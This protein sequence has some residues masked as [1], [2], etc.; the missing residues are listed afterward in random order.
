MTVPRPEYP[1]PQ[2]VRDGY[3]NLNGEWEF[4]FDFGRSG[5]DRKM[6]EN[7]NFTKKIIVPF[8]PESKLSGIEYKDFMNA[9]WYR[10]K[11]TVP[12]DWK[13][14]RTY[15]HFGAVD[16]YCEVYIN[17]KKV[18]S[19]AG[20]YTPFA[21]DITDY[22][23]EG[24]NT[25]VVMAE[26]DNRSGK[27]PRGKQ[28][29]AYYSHGC[30]YTRTTGIWQTVWLEKVS[31]NHIKHF[32]YYP[33]PVECAVDI[34]VDIT[35]PKGG[36]KLL[37]ETFFEGRPTGSKTVL[38]DG[39]ATMVHIPL[40]EKHLWDVGV[41][42]LY[43]VKFTLFVD[44][45]KTDQID[46]YFGLR[47]VSWDDNAMYLNGRPVFQR[48]VL[49]QGFYPDG[50][51]TAPTD[52]DLLND[53][54]L[55][56]DLGF[57][58]ARLHEKIFEPRFL[59]WSDKMGYLVWGEH[60]NWGLEI[61]NGDGIRNFLP[62][63]MEALK[64]DFNHPSIIGWCPF[65]E[66]WDG[67]QRQDNVV[68]STVYHATKAI[69][70]TRPVIDTS[71]NYHVITDIFDVHDYTQDFEKF[72]KKYEAVKHGGEHYCSFPDRQKYEGQPYF[73]SEFGGAW[74]SNEAI[75]GWGY[76]DR[77]KSPD[78]VA[79]RYEALAS[80]LLDH[81]HI[82]AFCYTQL[83]DVEQE[84]NGFYTYDRKRKLTDSA[85]ERIKA[86]NKKRAAIEKY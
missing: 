56:M 74:W 35:Y 2:M 8:C 79:E 59:Y 25:V 80:Y 32:R 61:H 3:I 34:Q 6:Y 24:E 38:I 51:Y 41:G 62:E 63:W 14:Y 28:S 46:S 45:Q 52:E 21:F 4:E 12:D 40:S 58:G 85:Y 15:I 31:E 17:A 16:Y 75:D 60:G 57:N 5:R 29:A 49:D 78:E 39:H 66:T 22:L 81:P 11:F 20:G 72:Y 69:D 7:G 44:G 43:D 30:D 54:K 37:V 83:Y 55:S 73:V 26:D 70:P 53:I 50:V 10:R 76:G 48:L 18:G 1:R 36:A 13:G 68:L 84:K 47:S 9:V 64:R 77:P 86:V 19:H 82:C 23:V 67:K 27:Q 33:N 71:G 42:N 65:N